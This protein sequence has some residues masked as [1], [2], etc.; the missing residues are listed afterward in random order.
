MQ[1]FP[2]NYSLY[3]NYGNIN[4]NN[5][6]ISFEFSNAHVSIY[7][8]SMKWASG[9]YGNDMVKGWKLRPRLRKFTDSIT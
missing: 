4:L 7:V 9:V 5:F 2:P 8:F 1:I 3:E 6:D